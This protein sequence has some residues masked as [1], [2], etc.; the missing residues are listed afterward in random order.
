MTWIK[1]NEYYLKCNEWTICK[2]APPHFEYGL[3]HKNA[4]KGFFMT[5]KEAKMKYE[6]I[7]ND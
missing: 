5:S 3:F 7:N 1:H 2:Y 6:S 4:N